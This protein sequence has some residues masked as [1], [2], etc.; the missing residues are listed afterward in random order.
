MK[1]GI[2]SALLV[3]VCWAFL[4]IAQLWAAPLPAEVFMKVSITAGIVLA[5]IVV[6]TLVVREYLSE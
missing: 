5:I 3:A 1:F 6:V 4:A 2:V